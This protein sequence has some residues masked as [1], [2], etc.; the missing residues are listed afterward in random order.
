MLLI[1]L[2]IVLSTAAGVGAERRYGGRAGIAS[3]QAL[4]FVLY[5]V[6][7]YVVFVNLATTELDT[8]LAAGVVLGWIAVG[9]AAFV[10]YLIGS[11]VLDVPR[12]VLGAMI[13]TTLIANTGYLGYPLVG[14]LL[15][16]DRVGEAVVYDIGVGAPALLL[17][18]FATGAAFGTKSGETLRQRTVAFFTR[19]PPLFAAVAALIVP[20]SAIPDLAVDASRILIITLLPLGFFA[21]GAA[22]E[23]EAEEGLLRFPPPLTGPTT[24][25]IFTRLMLVP[26]LLF[27]LSAPLIDIPGPFLILAAMPSGLNSMIVAHAYGLDLRTTAE[28]VTWT[29]ILAVTGALIGAAIF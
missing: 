26:A 10:A 20:A 8:D 23:E 18:G 19:N 22:L 6:L 2:A 15:G 25:V 1:V 27:G 12:P 4:T 17:A 14:T 5:V 29:T 28:A 13:A 16:F 3:R 21:V 24:T 7:P 9:T 11:R